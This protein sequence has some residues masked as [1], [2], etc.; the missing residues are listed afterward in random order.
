MIKLAN[1]FQIKV[2]ELKGFNRI[3]ISTIK[4]FT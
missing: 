1:N 3:M 2:G 4:Q